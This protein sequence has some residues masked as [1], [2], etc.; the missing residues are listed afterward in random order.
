MMAAKKVEVRWEWIGEAWK[1]Y[2][3]NPGAWI[4]MV[5]ITGI[6]GILLVALPIVFILVPAGI[7]ASRY[8]QGTIFAAAGL[9]LLLIPVLLIA[10]LL[11]GT[12]LYCGMYRAAIRQAQGESVAVGDLFSGG[13]RFLPV[14]G[15]VVLGIIANIAVRIIFAGPGLIIDGL[16]PL[17]RLAAS[18][19]SVI[20]YGFIF[21]AIPLIID[22]DM[23]VFAAINAS[24]EA[25]K[26]Q[27]WMFAIFVFAL[28]LLSLSG[29][30]GCGVGLLVT[31]PFVFTTTAVAYR[32]T[33]DLSD[34]QDYGMFTPPPPDN[35]SYTP[36]QDPDEQLAPPPWS[37]PT[38]VSPSV[39]PPP[40]PES[41]SGTCPH[42]GVTLARVMNFCNQCGSPLRSA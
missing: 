40:A 7:F 29:I 36:A 27:W 10:W 23:G 22:R 31:A 28:G 24:I 18:V 26:S 6:I 9:T 25:T 16:A 4:G 15:L 17:G 11:L 1:L 32:D 8:D 41:T 13:D 19:I 5:S 12:Y 20:I 38:F 34:A 21:F 35:W 33:F 37:A 42:C 30:I 3:N 39:A 2:T 14:L